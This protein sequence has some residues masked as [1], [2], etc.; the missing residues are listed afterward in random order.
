VNQ[1]ITLDTPQLRGLA[2]VHMRYSNHGKPVFAYQPAAAI[3]STTT[4]CPSRNGCRT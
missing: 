2:Y 4:S 3:S 1:E